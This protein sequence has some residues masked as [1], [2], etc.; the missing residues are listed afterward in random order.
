MRWERELNN[1]SVSEV[2]R[3]LRVYEQLL[4]AEGVPFSQQ[5]LPG[6]SDLNAIQEKVEASAGAAPD[7]LVAWFQWQGGV[8]IGPELGRATI[9]AGFRP[10]GLTESIESTREF[11]WKPYGYP[12]EVGPTNPWVLLAVQSPGSTMLISNVFTGEIHAVFTHGGD[13]SLIAHSVHEMIARWSE[14]WR[15]AM[16][17]VPGRGM[18]TKIPYEQI[19]AELRNQDGSL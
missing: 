18:D 6:E 5:K 2:L 3:E 10:L 17:W 19:P 15:V 12:A 9:F 7:D 4:T 1:T 13:S 14:L 8:P 16:K 11:R